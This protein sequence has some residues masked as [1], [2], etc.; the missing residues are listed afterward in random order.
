[1]R[2]RTVISRLQSDNTTTDLTKLTEDYGLQ[3]AAGQV[4][5][6]DKQSWVKDNIGTETA[7][8]KEEAIY[9]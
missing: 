1:M 6:D 3:A 5:E 4:K 7:V 9:S 8:K 2:E